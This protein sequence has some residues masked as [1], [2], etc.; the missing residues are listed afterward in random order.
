MNEEAASLAQLCRDMQFNRDNGRNAIAAE[1]SQEDALGVLDA[2]DT[3]HRL[4]VLNSDV[5]HV[6]QSALSVPLPAHLFL[7]QECNLRSPHYFNDSGVERSVPLT[8][9]EIKDLLIKLE[10]TGGEPLLRD[11]FFDILSLAVSLGFK[12]N[13]TS[14]GTLIDDITAQR[15]AEF[16]PS[17]R[18]F[19]ISIEGPE[20]AHDSICGEG[21][22]GRVVEALKAP[23]KCRGELRFYRYAQLHRA[24]FARS[25]D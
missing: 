15:R 3:L 22:F 19:L 24:L 18:F 6:I 23:Q 20:E 2:L 8:F 13:G 17:F 21:R 14:D 16:D 5:A 9:R 25:G 4:G 12:M 10:R 1:L 7:T 11:G